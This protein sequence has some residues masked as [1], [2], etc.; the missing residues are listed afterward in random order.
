M[1][2][3][4]QL[5]TYDAVLITII[6]TCVA[7]SPLGNAT[8]SDGKASYS[9]SVVTPMYLPDEQLIAQYERTDMTVLVCLL[10][11]QFH[12]AGPQIEKGKPNF[13]PAYIVIYSA[14]FLTY[15]ASMSALL[16]SLTKYVNV[17]VL[18][19]FT[20]H[21]FFHPNTSQARLRTE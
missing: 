6:I 1:Y 15:F 3:M 12:K 18:G 14:L 21:H 8:G 5:L 7:G 17:L 13:L 2:R 11:G 16:S 4:A 19:P 20:A 10:V 9:C